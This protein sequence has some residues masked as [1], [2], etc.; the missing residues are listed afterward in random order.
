MLPIPEIQLRLLD[1]DERRFA[2]LCNALLAEYAVLEGSSSLKLSLNAKT[3]EPDGGID[4]RAEGIVAAPSRL[5][6]RPN[7][8][9]Q[10]KS[11]RTARSASTIAEDDIIGK[12]RVLKGLMDGRALVYMRPTDRGDQFEDDIRAELKSRGVE[13]ED[14]QLRYITGTTLAT[15]LQ[16]CPALVAE[17]L[18][19]DASDLLTLG[20]W[21]GWKSLDNDFQRDDEVNARLADIAAAI[22][23]E[24]S[25]T[26]IV[27]AAGDG[28]T[29]LVL[30]ALRGTE[31]A[32]TVLY[33]RDPGCVPP[34]LISFL[35]RKPDT[36]CTLVV[37]EVDEE[38]AETLAAQLSGRGPHVRLV[39][40]GLDVNHRGASGVYRVSGLS[41][42]V[43][44]R[45]VKDIAPTIS[46]ERA[47]AVA[48]DCHN[49]PKL[50]VVIAK[51]LRAEPSLA[52]DALLKNPG[53]RGALD[54][55]LGLDATR[56]DWKALSVLSLLTRVGWSEDAEYES[57]LLFETMGVDVADGRRHVQDIHETLG[58]A[59]I[60][61][62]FRY[63]SP[64]ILAD[65]LA[66]RLLESWDR[67]SL[68]T[69][70]SALSPDMAKSF[71]RRASRIAASLE[72]RRAVAD[73]LFGPN[74]LLSNA[75]ALEVNGNAFFLQALTTSYPQEVLG[76]IER[77]VESLSKDQLYS[78]RASRRALVEALQ[79]LQ[80]RE[81]L[82]Q[83]ASAVLLQLGV[84]ENEAWSNN[85]S[86]VWSATFP[87][88]L[89]GTAAG[90][91]ARL[92]VLRTAAHSSQVEAR[93]LAGRALK[94]VFETRQ[95]MRVGSPPT[96]VVGW[97]SD[98]WRPTTYA[99]WDRALRDG[100][101][102]A[103]VL[104][105]DD[106]LEVRVT[107]AEALAELAAA[108]PQ[109]G[110]EAFAAWEA[111]VAD[112]GKADY[113]LRGPVLQA[114]RWVAKHQ[115]PDP[116][117]PDREVS[118]DGGDGETAD[119][120]AAEASLG[121][122]ELKVRPERV[123][124]IKAEIGLLGGG[125][126]A[127]RVRATLERRDAFDGVSEEALTGELR[128]LARELLSGASDLE[129][130]LTAL[131]GEQKLWRLEWWVQLLAEEDAEERCLPILDALSSTSQRAAVWRNIYIVVRALKTNEP[132]RII[133]DAEAL[134]AEGD[135]DG[136]FDLLLRAGWSH[137]RGPALL[138]VISHGALSG[139][140]F[141][142]LAYSPW[143]PSLSLSAAQE[144]VRAAREARV[145]ATAI[146]SVLGSILHDHPEFRDALADDALALLEHACEE[147]PNRH[148]I[149]D[150]T[151]VAKQF[152]SVRPM[153]IARLATRR[154]LVDEVRGED[155]MAE[156]LMRA[157]EAGD[158][159]LLFTEAIGPFI[160][161][162]GLK[163]HFAKEAL[164][165]L[166][167]SAVGV[168]DLVAWAKVDHEHRPFALAYAVGAPGEVVSEL[169]A[170]LLA[171]FPAQ[172]AS[173]FRSRL[174]S[175][176][177]WGSAAEWTQGKLDL[178]KRWSTDDR[179]AV[180]GW[181][182]DL[183]QQLE[184]SVTW[185]QQREAENQF[186]D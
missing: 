47:L 70:V 112:L 96:D 114:L 156:V 6:P 106:V 150:W 146:T 75:E 162:R 69:F 73:A 4:A 175:G 152:A 80:W 184:Q 178:A 91:P 41:P 79:V 63:V 147:L 182:K 125:A 139:R 15:W 103:R 34:G 166:E 97:P 37:D 128:Q 158:K 52:R 117:E 89:G 86:G 113:E 76:A 107:V 62:R 99:E 46:D 123:V 30:E 142:R 87:M 136:A 20:D 144:I 170:A 176:S 102:L 78:M 28:K 111:V 24:R 141:A 32:S 48:D 16:R 140:V 61:G 183:V 127:V 44:S 165:H 13:I 121:E 155:E 88:I 83:R 116:V 180:S 185:E 115:M 164:T 172:A 10:Y 153:E 60:A 11:G 120:G 169:H 19:V 160:E 42:A 129:Q 163:A 124:A 55:Y 110:E 157:W 159:R 82:F 67:T 38:A 12:P 177:F 50:A 90:W 22:A 45:I 27:G 77:A 174:M 122:P 167:L 58:V 3:S 35:R 92:E 126:W 39:L 151:N 85:A 101:E 132:Q 68:Q 109:L 104:L 9:F 53:L 56:P 43:L 25:L 131:A 105:S 54:G 84:A 40:I 181:A 148:A 108:T 31:L 179:P 98:S 49:S 71:A 8:D 95:F 130:E 1:L 81:D 154:L 51:L 168:A 143:V 134:L 94:A 64:S 186:N 2:E 59:P 33:A 23:Q 137:E 74:G 171:E 93:I 66:A 119:V 36:R 17:F 65:Y 135:S 21:S 138:R 118:T 26:R 145:E 149:Y 18:G 100:V 161:A 29:R 14:D 133:S 5:F 7:V 57:A 173:A 72:N